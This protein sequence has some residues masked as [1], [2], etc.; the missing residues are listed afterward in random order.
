[1]SLFSNDASTLIIIETDEGS[2]TKSVHHAVN[3]WELKSRTLECITS[4]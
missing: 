4:Y 1:M 3:Y 2:G